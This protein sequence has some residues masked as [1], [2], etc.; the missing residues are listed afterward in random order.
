MPAGVRLLSGCAMPAGVRIFPT[1]IVFFRG[2]F[3]FVLFGLVW[4]GLVCLVCLVFFVAFHLFLP[5]PSMF[6]AR[7]TQ[8]VE[9]QALNLLAAGTSPASGYF[10]RFVFFLSCAKKKGGK[11]VSIELTTSCTQSKNHTPKPLTRPATHKANSLSEEGTSWIIYTVKHVEGSVRHRVRVVKEV[12]KKST[13]LYPP[14]IE[15]LRRRHFYAFNFGAMGFILFESRFCLGPVQ[16]LFI[17]FFF[18]FFFDQE[19]LRWDEQQIAF[20]FWFCFFAFFRVECAAI[21]VSITAR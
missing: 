20:C 10:C 19:Q 7:V 3:C 5:A 16:V 17:F 1:S 15:S 13:A 6:D 4:F 2:V 18:F 11:G 8:S 21:F 14:E 9:W 12:D